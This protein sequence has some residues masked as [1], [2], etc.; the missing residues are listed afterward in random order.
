MERLWRA[1]ERKTKGEEEKEP[2]RETVKR[3]KERDRKGE[4]EDK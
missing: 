1:K 2:N 3:E 4:R